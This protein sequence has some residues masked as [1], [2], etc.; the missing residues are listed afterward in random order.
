VPSHSA[1]SWS[2]ARSLFACVG[3][4]TLL[5][6]G[7]DRGPQL[8]EGAQHLVAA[9]A[10]LAKGDQALALKEL[11]AAIAAKPNEWAYLERAKLRHAA[12]SDAD[13]AADCEAGLA[14]APDNPD[15]KWL[16]SEL[17]KPKGQQFHGESAQ[18]PS[19]T[20]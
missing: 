10:A 11:D 20:K 19:A 2:P 7:C 6:L 3:L 4:T 8:D 5:L 13:A 15:L 16:Q 18:P 17:K 9:R 1:P 14:L 12:G